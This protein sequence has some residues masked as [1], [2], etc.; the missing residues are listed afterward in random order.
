MSVSH[1]V[2]SR[3]RDRHLQS[4]VVFCP[5]QRPAL[6]ACI[7]LAVA[8]ATACTLLEP[9]SDRIIALEVVGRSL[10]S[11]TA[12]DTVQLHARALAANGDTVPGAK[13]AWALMDTGSVGI[14]LLDS[15]GTVIAHGVG[16]WQLQA[17]VTD[18][19]SSSNVIRSDPVVIVVLP[20]GANT[21]T[22]SELTGSVPAGTAIND[23]LT[24]LDM[25]SN[26]AAGYTGTVHF[27]SSDT[28]A[29]LPT[30]YTFTS[31]DAGRRGFALTLMTPGV[32]SITA[33]DI[34]NGT[35]TAT[36]MIMVTAPPAGT[37]PRPP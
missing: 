21:I 3:G 15:S 30:D 37:G 19:Q 36:Q 14:I 29:A 6:L 5:G 22:F 11:V 35:L 4:P 25:Y 18:A 9:P 27:M 20:A 23:T 34:A 12:G 26:V 2:R 24:A 13:I 28:A 8:I 33:S 7:Y 17:S 16:R 32:Q 10:D 31:A 1:H